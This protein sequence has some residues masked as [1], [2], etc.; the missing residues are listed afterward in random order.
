MPSLAGLDSRKE[1]R[2]KQIKHRYAEYYCHRGASVRMLI[3]HQV[4]RRGSWALQPRHRPISINS[5]PSCWRGEPNHVGDRRCPP[6]LVEILKACFDVCGHRSCPPCRFCLKFLLSPRLNTS[7]S[8]GVSP[9]HTCSVLDVKLS[10]EILLLTA[11]VARRMDA[12]VL[13]CSTCGGNDQAEK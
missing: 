9:C 6:L 8:D 12:T 7:L 4:V 5:L 3:C 13:R 1:T 2:W 10:D 11:G